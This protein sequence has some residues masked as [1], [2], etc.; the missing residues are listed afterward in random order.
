MIN[1][2]EL[3]KELHNL[4][5]RKFADSTLCDDE[6]SEPFGCEYEKGMYF[7]HW[8]RETYEFD[9][10]AA[11]EIWNDLDNYSDGEFGLDFHDYI[12]DFIEKE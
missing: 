5:Y 7:L 10:A 8:R 11:L 6:V 2:K 4:V 3:A 9:R 12:T 1:D